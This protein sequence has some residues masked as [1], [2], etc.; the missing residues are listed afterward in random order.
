MYDLNR[1]YYSKTSGN[2]SFNL[3]EQEKT[4]LNSFTAISGIASIS[5]ICMNFIML[6]NPRDKARP[7]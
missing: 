6:R 2:H 1:S 7:H 5:A 4:L 3:S